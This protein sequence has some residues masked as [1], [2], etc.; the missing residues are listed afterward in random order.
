MISAKKGTKQARSIENVVEQEE[1]DVLDKV[2]G[3]AS[4][5]WQF[6]KDLKEVSELS[7]T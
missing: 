2:A 1:G 5:R 3:K 4:L 7:A 6:G